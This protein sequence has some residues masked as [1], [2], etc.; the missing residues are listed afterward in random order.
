M[1]ESRVQTKIK[2][3]IEKLGGKVINGVYTATGEADLQCG[4]PVNGVLLY[5]AIEVKTPKMYEKMMQSIYIKNN[6]YEIKDY[7]YLKDH[8]I[9][10]LAKLNDVRDR[11]GLAILA[12]SWE[13]VEE[14]IKEATLPVAIVTMDVT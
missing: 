11:G 8:E 14:Y 4:Y 5:L 13:R 10:Q 1:K 6:R 7:D 3:E 12:D 2:K 9:L